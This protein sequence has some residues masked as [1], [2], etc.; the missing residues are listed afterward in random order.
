MSYSVIGKR[1][2]RHDAKEKV[3]GQAQFVSDVYLPNM[4]YGKILRSPYAHARIHSID[5]SQ[6]SRVPGVRAIV[7]GKDAL[8]AYNFGIEIY[9]EP[10]L[11]WDGMV[12]YVGQEVAAVAA[13]DSETA[14]EAIDLIE[15]DYEELPDVFDPIAAMQPGAPQVHPELSEVRNNIGFEVSIEEGNVEL[16][17]KEGD[18]VLEDDFT[19]SE[20]YQGY[21]EP[22]G[23]IASYDSGGN[24]T[25]WVGNI[26]PSHVR[27]ELAR[28]LKI[29]ISKIRVLQNHVGG[30]FGGKQTFCPLHFITSLLAMKTGRPVK[31][32]LS[33]AED[34]MITRHRCSA[35]THVKMGAKKD[36]T[37]TA[38]ET[39]V[40]VDNGAYQYL[41]RRMATLM[42]LRNDANYRLRNVRYTCKNV[43]TNKV[44]IGPYR[45]YGEEEMTFPRESMIDMMAHAIGMDTAEFKMR[46]CPH[47]GDVTIHGWPLNSCGLAECIERATEKARWKEKRAEKRAGR[48]IGIAST[49]KET[50][51]RYGDAFYGSVTF[52]K[53]LE[54]G[55]VQVITGETDCG[56]GMYNA[57]A[58]VAAEEL[59]LQP[60]DIEVS[61]FDSSVSPWALGWWGSRVVSSA[62][63]ATRDAALKVRRLILERAAQMLQTE[64]EL[65]DMKGGLV[66]V[67]N[68]PDKSLTLAEIGLAARRD[69]AEGSVIM[70]KG[71]EERA[72]TEWTLKTSHPTHYGPSVSAT[73]FDTT[74]VEV[75]V[76]PK[77]GEV[78]TLNVV[79]ADDCGRILDL[80]SLEGQVQGGTVQGLGAALME[81][82]LFDEGKMLTTDFLDY[83]VPLMPNVPPIEKIFVETNEPGFAYGCKGGGEQAGIGSIMPALA[84]AIYDATGVRIHSTPL[85]REK[86]LAGLAHKKGE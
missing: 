55:R 42:G 7:S 78:S 45:G 82:L 39:R 6:A 34:F 29:P 81:E 76:N 65:L 35:R 4:L 5:A 31:I 17:F 22:D 36:G 53:L 26:W 21:L 84:N 33:R 44:P 37:I 59:G 56:Q 57:V 25:I 19:T 61:K 12:R 85:T 48:G 79:V 43:Y 3:T 67:K 2:P 9:D 50:D 40:V 70:A 24:L 73:Y 13:L 16:G 63:T 68:S 47:Q 15:V 69:K 38:L 64:P 18:V 1:F 86:I 10:L 80:M 11:A 75:E 72:S 28:A 20:V 83:R 30:A 23:C 27:D 51:D 74:V 66:Y 8:R 62:V 41:A 54:D 49:S 32:V 71:M 14:T 52:V 60:Q 46:N 58:M 77:T